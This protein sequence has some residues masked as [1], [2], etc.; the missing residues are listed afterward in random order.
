[1]NNIASG[2]GFTAPPTSADRATVVQYAALRAAIRSQALLVHLWGAFVCPLPPRE[3]SMTMANTEKPIAQPNHL[4][5]A[6]PRY[7]KTD[8][9]LVRMNQRGIRDADLELALKCSS[10]VGS[11]TYLVRRKDIEQEI[12]HR[13]R[14]IR[15]LERIKGKK[16]IMVGDVLVTVY[17]SESENHR[18]T[19][20]KRRSRR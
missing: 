18:S 10:D 17:H 9:A 2:V 12:Q 11:G 7:R 19:Q 16:L 1:M 13:K 20:R 3:R 6:K 15:A 8:H 14:E 5:D 4:G